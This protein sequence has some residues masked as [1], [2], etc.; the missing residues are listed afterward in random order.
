MKLVETSTISSFLIFAFLLAACNGKNQSSTSDN[1]IVFDTIS[2]NKVYHMENDSTKPSC[3]LKIK[4]IAPTEYSDSTILNQIRKELSSAFFGSSAYN[5]QPAKDAVLK[6]TDDYIGLYK[7]DAETLF[8]NWDESDESEDY[9]SYYKTM[10]SSVTY[11]KCDLISYQIKSMEYKGGA[12]AY[13]GYKNITVSLKN[14]NQI[15][16]DDIFVK[17]Y[18][19]VLDEL[20]LLKLKQQNKAESADALFELG[21]S[22]IEDFTSN[23]NFLIDSEGVSYIFNQGDY[24]IPTLGEIRIGLTFS[25]L[26]PILKDDSPISSLTGR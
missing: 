13:T 21:Y 12:N 2:I 15:K 26:T 23:N 14:G 17:G 4:Y 22:R 19:K 25:E 16:E 3:S 18:K 1:D 20:L 9:F 8:A 7:T 6:Y 10:E 11:N 24:S 5:N